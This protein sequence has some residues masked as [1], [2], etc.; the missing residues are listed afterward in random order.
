MSAIRFIVLVLIACAAI[1]VSAQEAG[2]VSLFDGES[3]DGWHQRNG[4][5]T[6]RVEENMIIGRTNEG[7][8][9][10]CLCSD[11]AY[12]DFELVFEVKCDAPLNS[13]VQIRSQSR[14]DTPEGR[15]NGPQVEIESGNDSGSTAGYIYGEAAGGW[16][17]PNEDRNKH[18]HF[19]REDWN[20][21]RVVATGPRIQVWVNGN[22]VSDLVHEEKFETHP[23]GFIGLQVHGIG[24]GKGPFEVRWRNIAIRDLTGFVSL[25][26]GEDLTGWKT[27]GNW[28]PQ[29]DGSLLIEPRE[30]ENGWQRYDAYIWSEKQYADFVLDLEYTY[31]RGGNSG[32]FFR[33]AETADP[34]AQGIEVQILDSSGKEGELGH[35]DHGGIIRTQGPTANM[36]REPGE[37]NHMVVSCVGNHLQVWLNGR[38]IHDLQLNES[39]MSDRPMSGFIGLQDHGVPN[40]LR[41]RG[42][43]IREIEK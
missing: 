3:L 23:E 33:V 17:T 24:R 21:Y 4:T 25:Y 34:V 16:M 2:Y 20:H 15:V 30:G 5:A 43:R 36:S 10:S 11:R 7:S 40:N 42:I 6:Y 37:W 14:G 13:G 8:P 29:E 32:V 18:Q 28:L 19:K 35:H 1:P 22:Q 12:G 27:E 31:P 38:Q 26:N 41:F 9:N 39:A